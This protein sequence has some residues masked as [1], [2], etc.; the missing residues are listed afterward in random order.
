[1]RSAALAYLLV[2]TVVHAQ[3][4]R[5][6]IV[7]SAR[8]RTVAGSLREPTPPADRNVA[9]YRPRQIPGATPVGASAGAS[10]GASTGTG[11]VARVKQ[12]LARDSSDAALAV[13]RP[14]LDAEPNNAAYHLWMAAIYAQRSARI[15][16]VAQL[17]AT[18]T[19]RA[20]LER[21]VALDSAAV[22]AVSIDAHSELARFYLTAPAMLGGSYVKAER[23]IAVL[24]RVSPARAHTLRGY[25]AHHTGNLRIAETEMRAAISAA[26]DSAMGYAA[27]AALLGEQQRNDEAFLLWQQAVARDSSLMPAYTAMGNI[28][29]TT[30]T[31][32]TD[33][34]LALEHYAAH[35][36]RPTDRRDRA[37][38]AGWL[39]IVYKKQGRMADAR[40]QYEQ[41][42]VFMP[43]RAEYVDSLKRLPR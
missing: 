13:L 14:A 3:S 12:L 2:A 41:A 28:G 22:T 5:R 33:A 10:A 11:T 8:T 36:P 17:L 20:E 21:A 9:E 43:D 4:S 6:A 34:A 16:I 32:L 26:P 23:E 30:G 31:H 15:N 38:A 40:K 39:A 35:P 19:M 18:R 37:R 7:D 42:L 24:E 1:M 25:L 27:L 29:A